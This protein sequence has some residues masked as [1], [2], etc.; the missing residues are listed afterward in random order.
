MVD[1]IRDR[2][3]LDLDA[4][5]NA[6]GRIKFQGEW[7]DV[8]PPTLEQL[9]QLARIKREIGKPGID[10]VEG[11][12]LFAKAREDL[13][14]FLPELAGKLRDISE[15]LGVLQFMDQLATPNDVEELTRRRI[16]P[17]NDDQKKALDSLG[18]GPSED[19]ATSTQDIL[20]PQ[21]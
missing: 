14:E 17:L 6:P 16:T 3:E 7:F 8:Q 4:L 15:I 9:V 21:S 19:S 2:E 20:L 1:N 13:K 18:L 10:E 11:L 12:E 5:T